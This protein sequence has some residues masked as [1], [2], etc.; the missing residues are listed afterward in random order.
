MDS[1]LPRVL[2]TD[3]SGPSDLAIDHQ[4]RRLYWSELSGRIVRSDLN[5]TNQEVVYS[6]PSAT[7]FKIALYKKYL[8]WID[9][10]SG[11]FNVIHRENTDNRGSV[12][13][14]PPPSPTQSLVLN[15][16][17]VVGSN[18]QL[19]LGESH[20]I[21][22]AVQTLVDRSSNDCFPIASIVSVP[23]LGMCWNNSIVL[24][25]LT[26]TYQCV[27]NVPGCSHYCNADDED[28]ASCSCPVGYSLSGGT[29][30]TCESLYLADILT[31]ADTVHNHFWST[32]YV[33]SY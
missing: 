22:T 27:Q 5:G 33:S 15:G 16:L 3:L 4:T 21:L 8:L 18:R 17:L 32:L 11:S 7:P 9:G 1:L 10:T 31:T 28:T 25:L 29:T 30:C 19:S 2:V 12:P 14:V 13:I 24:S 26:G 6:D 23:K 20:N